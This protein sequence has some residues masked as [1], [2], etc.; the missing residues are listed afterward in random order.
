MMKA[1]LARRLNGWWYGNTALVWPLVPLSWLFRGAV[2]VRRKAYEWG[3][4]KI[5]WMPVPVIVVGNITVGGSGKTPLVIWL[6]DYLS[7][8]GYSPG[9]VSRGYGGRARNWPQQVRAD[10]DPVSVGDEAVVLARRCNCPVAV[11]PD[12]GAA[13][14]ALLA[15]TECNVIIADDG[16]QHY[17]LGRDIE[18]AVLDGVRRLG[19]R[20]FLP[21]GPLREHPRRLEEVDFIVTNGLAGRGEYGMRLHAGVARNLS[22]ESVV[23]G[24]EAFR[25]RPLHAVAGIGNPDRFFEELRKHGLE[26][27]AHAFPDHHQYRAEDVEFSDNADVLMTEKDAVKCRRFAQ[28]RHW[29]VPVDA[30][31]NEYFGPRL[32]ATLQNR[33]SDG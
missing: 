28:R 23:R 8:A 10:S 29:Y 2:F 20:H 31:L 25:G 26:F 13:A 17:A 7:R 30:E 11:G 21:A 14:R 6:A 19:N 15:H 22:D 32:L 18:L 3:A 1:L 33:S 5:G 4:R 12:R 16:L 27:Q 9:V 24:I